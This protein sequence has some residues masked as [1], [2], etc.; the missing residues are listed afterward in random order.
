[1]SLHTPRDTWSHP[2]STLLRQVLVSQDTIGGWWHRYQ[3][4]T[5]DA[6]GQ[7]VPL[8]PTMRELHALSLLG[9]ISDLARAV[10]HYRGYEHECPAIAFAVSADVGSILGA[11]AGKVLAGGTI[12]WGIDVE[13]AIDRL[14]DLRAPLAMGVTDNG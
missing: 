2:A 13:P 1:M 4:Q 11:T 14:H 10:D 7:P 8:G 6:A 5:T 9:E 12:Y 3:Y